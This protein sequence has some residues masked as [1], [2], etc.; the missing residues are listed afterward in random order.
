MSRNDSVPTDFK[1]TIISRWDAPELPVGCTPD[2]HVFGFTRL[3]ND[4][5]AFIWDGVAGE[6]ISEAENARGLLFISDDGRHV[7]VVLIRRGRSQVV[8]DG[9]E[10]AVVD[11]VSAS[12]VPTFSPDGRRLAF[13]GRIGDAHRLF[14]DGAVASQGALAPVGVA[15]SQSGQRVAWAEL[16]GTGKGDQVRIVVD[17]VPGDWFIGLRNAGGAMQFSPDGRRFAYYQVD[18]SGHGRWVVDGVPQQ[19]AD[20]V[21]AI[22]LKQLLGIGVQEPSLPA[23]FSPDGARF[24]YAADVPG[25][26]VAM[27]EDDRPG[28]LVRG[29]GDPVFS[30][31]GRRLAYVALRRD[32]SGALIVDGQELRRFPNVLGAGDPVW[33]ADS[34]H[35]AASM[36]REEGGFLRKRRYAAVMVDERVI[37]D[38]EADDASLRPVFSRD[39][40]LAYWLQSRGTTKLYVDGTALDAAVAPAGEPEFAASGAL[41]FHGETQHGASIAVDGRALAPSRGLLLPRGGIPRQHRESQQPFR[42]DPLSSRIAW[43]ATFDDELPHPVLDGVV[44]P[45]YDDVMNWT[46]EADGTPVWW[47]RRGADVFRVEV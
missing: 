2:G 19:W 41:V 27:V 1:E 37:V 38:A 22:G 31:D 7:A 15:F 43:V 17:G 32:G 21:R 18:G 45:A 5:L 11:E 33:T 24:A 9:R 3:P 4:H 29:C 25:K 6:P 16:S 26:G 39:G 42:I 10:E 36:Q 34:R 30:P 44:G 47:A 23:C 46:F 35:V 14:L 40:R 8:R 12:V 28:P 20:D 13:G